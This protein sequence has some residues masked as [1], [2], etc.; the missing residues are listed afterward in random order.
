MPEQPEGLVFREARAG[1]VPAIVAMLAEDSV[2]AGR[3]GTEMAPYLAAFARLAADPRETL[4]VGE[5]GGRI[6]ATCQLSVLDGLSRQGMRRAR[7]EAVRVLPALR[8][9]RIGAALIAEAEGRARAAGCGLI[10]LTT[11]MRR[12]RA[13]RFYD[14]LGYERSHYGFK[15]PLG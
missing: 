6:V 8:G 12:E 2:A 11:D 1:D 15:K 14:R 7:I 3:E 10:E 4:L 13:H 9:Q 5:Q